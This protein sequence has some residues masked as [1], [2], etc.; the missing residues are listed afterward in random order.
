[1]WPIRWLSKVETVV[2]IIQVMKTT[3]PVD[4]ADAHCVLIRDGG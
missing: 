1:M 4:E 3:L 2:G